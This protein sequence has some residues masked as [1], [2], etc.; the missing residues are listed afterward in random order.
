MGARKEVS[1]GFI[2]VLTYVAV[3]VGILL[4]IAVIQLA[5]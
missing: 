1:F 2:V 5:G 4:G 3:G